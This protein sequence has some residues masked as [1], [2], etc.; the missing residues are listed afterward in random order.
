[1][2][3]LTNPH[4]GLTRTLA[5]ELSPAIRVNCIA[6]SL[7]RTSLAAKVSRLADTESCPLSNMP[8]FSLGLPSSKAGFAKAS[9]GAAVTLPAF[10]IDHNVGRAAALCG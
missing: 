6:P 1:M 7:V 10:S 5:A 8:P 3:A 2:W 4:K 9:T